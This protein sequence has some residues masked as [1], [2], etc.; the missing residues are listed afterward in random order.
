M[1]ESARDWSSLEDGVL[2]AILANPTALR[3]A[4]T[5]AFAVIVTRYYH[6]LLDRTA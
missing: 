4:K 2:M 5:A 1:T 3:E 6:V